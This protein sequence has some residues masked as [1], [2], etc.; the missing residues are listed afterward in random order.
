MVI[1]RAYKTELAPTHE[2][3]K[4]L[5]RQAGMV[6]FV[7]N[8]GLARKIEARNKG[9]RTPSAKTLDN[10][11]RKLKDSLPEYAWLN[12]VASHPRQA[13]LANVDAAFKNFFARCKNKK[14]GKKG[15]PRFKSR[16]RGDAVGIRHFS[17]RIEEGHVNVSKIGRIKLKERGYLPV[18][19]YGENSC[20]RLLGLTITQ[21]AE[22]WFVSVQAEVESEQQQ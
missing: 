5:I 11:L 13:A 7:F 21:R 18:G 6:R 10:E 19:T 4:L 22:R 8:W 14:P 15:F 17:Y 2:Q 3:V 16:K 1:H 20:G 12:D 9:E